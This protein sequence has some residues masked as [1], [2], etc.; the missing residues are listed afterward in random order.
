MG[1]VSVKSTGFI[2]GQD[3]IE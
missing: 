2:R 1:D 3:V